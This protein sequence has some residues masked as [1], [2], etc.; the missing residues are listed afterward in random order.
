MDMKRKAFK[1]VIRNIKYI[2]I[3]TVKS[4]ERRGKVC[5]STNKKI[6]RLAW[7]VH[8]FIPSTEESEAGGSL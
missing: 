5:L 3:V 2:V 8:N 6:L 1:S 4:I 7:L